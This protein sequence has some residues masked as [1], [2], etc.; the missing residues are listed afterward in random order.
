M[1]YLLIVPIVLLAR[2]LQA[3]LAESTA[4]GEEFRGLTM[5]RSAALVAL[6]VAGLGFWLNTPWLVSLLYLMVVAFMFQGIAVLHARVRGRR[7]ARPILSVFYF[8][9]LI[10][11]QAVAPNGAP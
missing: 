3:S 8:V 4:F 5:G 7:S 11:P 2:W 10:A 9:L 6:V 1:L